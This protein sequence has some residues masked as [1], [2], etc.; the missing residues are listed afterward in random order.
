MLSRDI[1][2][3]RGNS[4]SIAFGRVRQELSNQIGNSR[5]RAAQAWLPGAWNRYFFGLGIRSFAQLNALLMQ[6]LFN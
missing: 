2:Y 4:S 5:G 1:L 6:E 3:L